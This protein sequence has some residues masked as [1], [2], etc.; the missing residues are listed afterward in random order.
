MCKHKQKI[1]TT[2]LSIYISTCKLNLT[3]NT[4]YLEA[5]SWNN[6]SIYMSIFY[7]R[8]LEVEDP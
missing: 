4:L 1:G 3:C 2:Y 5:Y 8:S 7:S 6:I